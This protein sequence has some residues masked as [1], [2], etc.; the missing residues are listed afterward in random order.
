M[1]D[2]ARLVNVGGLDRRRRR[3]QRQLR[4]F[5]LLLLR[6]HRQDR[7]GHFVGAIGGAALAAQLIGAEIHVLEPLE[8][9]IDRDVDGLRDRAVDVFLHRRLHHQMVGGRQRLGVDEIIGQRRAFA[10][11]TP[12]QAIGVVGHV[13]FLAAA[14]RHQD[15]ARVV[16]AEHRLEPRRDIVGEDR[17]RA[18]RRHGGQERVADAVRGDGVAQILLELNHAF[19]GEIGVAVEQAGTRPSPAPIPPR[20]DRPRGGWRASRSRSGLPPRPSHSARR[21]RSARRRGR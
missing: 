21:I 8:R 17:D 19:A 2:A 1:D 4:L 18:G 15:V 12:E 13:L 20:R 10:A 3:H 6:P 14:V 11:L 16:E 5:L 7:A 9:E